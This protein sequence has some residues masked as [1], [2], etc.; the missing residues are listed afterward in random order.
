MRLE[1]SRQILF[2]FFFLRAKVNNIQTHGTAMA[3]LSRV[4][5]RPWLVAAG[6]WLLAAHRTQHTRCKQKMLPPARG[7]LH[8]PA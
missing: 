4:E 6:P 5:Q 2:N 3:N 1:E 7:L 8:H